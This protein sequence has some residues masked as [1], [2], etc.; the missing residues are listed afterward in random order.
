ME[1]F[2]DFFHPKNNFPRTQNFIVSKFGYFL[3]S[4][5]VIFFISF[6]IYK[7]YYYYKNYT[8][9]FKQ[10]FLK[11]Y[12]DTNQKITFGVRLDK[13]WESEI[14][15]EFRNSNDDKINDD[16]ISICDENLIEIKKNET[17]EN[18]YKCLIDY[19]LNGSNITNHII[20]I[21]LRNN[22]KNKKINS[23]RIPL[24]VK[25]K[26]PKIDHDKK[27]DPFVFEN[28]IIEYIYYYTFDF[29]TSYRKYIKII[30][31]ITTSFISKYIKY[32][33]YLEDYEDTSKSLIKEKEEDYENII[34]SFR[35]CLSKKRD[36]IERKYVNWLDF[37][38]N[39]F[40]SL[41]GVMQVITF[42]ANITIIKTDNLRI[43]KNFTEKK[44]YLKDTLITNIEKFIE[45]KNIEIEYEKIKLKKKE[46]QKKE[47]N[48]C[49]KIIGLKNCLFDNDCCL[50]KFKKEKNKDI[51]WKDKLKFAIFGYCMCWCKNSKK[52]NFLFDIDDYFNNNI[53]I[54]HYLENQLINE[55]KRLELKNDIKN[56]FNL[57]KNYAKNNENY[58]KNYESKKFEFETRIEDIFSEIEK[59]N[60][61]NNKNNEN[62]KKEI[63]HN[64]NQH[65]EIQG[66]NNQIN[67]MEN[68]DKKDEIFIVK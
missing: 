43:F 50:I 52:N 18:I 15:L 65:N 32:S 37:L 14:N 26:E 66:D 67:E 35:F 20:K 29:Y 22:T 63:Q 5:F 24:F 48:C 62:E 57:E 47:K 2:F 39:F 38:L 23:E 27:N 10:D 36:I 8:I 25:F 59:E 53:T 44:P 4:S 68:Y 56:S 6:S 3:T 11:V 49:D 54:E 51:T 46:N 42:I 30:D 12:K 60:E 41:S 19:P 31:Y 28:E 16:L 40:A 7:R 21:H 33:L 13:N 58:F 17:N 9:S 45:K 1:E 55:K 61:V 34:G 64:E